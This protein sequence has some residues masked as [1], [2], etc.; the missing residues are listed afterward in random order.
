MV[1]AR[2]K[3]GASD[4]CSRRTLYVDED[5]WQTLA[6]DCYDA[7]GRLSRVQERHVI[8]YYEVPTIWTDL[9]LLMD[10]S[11]GGYVARG[12]QNQE[13]RSY[14]FSIRP[15]AADFQPSALERRDVR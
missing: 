4:P 2:L 6:V 15:T 1:E 8:N 10:L 3:Q 7:G 13:P 5:S 14:D 9:E 11:T 12:L